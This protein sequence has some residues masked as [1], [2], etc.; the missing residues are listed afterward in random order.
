MTPT[1]S[2]PGRSVWWTFPA[3]MVLVLV[4]RA[5]EPPG[6]ALVFAQGEPPTMSPAAPGGLGPRL[7]LSH[8]F[9]GSTPSLAWSPD[10]QRL[11][12]NAA[13]EYFGYDEQISEH[14]RSLGL[15]VYERDG[16]AARQLV[17]QQRYHPAW[18]GDA[19]IASGCSP[20]ESCTPGLYL[21]DLAGV[22]VQ[23]LAADVYHTVA[24]SDSQVLFYNG[25]SGYTRWNRFDVRTAAHE[26]GLSA[27]CSWE[28]PP[29]LY[30]DQCVQQV[31]EVS[32][33]VDVSSGLWVRYGEGAPLH[34]D[35]TPPFEFSS[36]AWD[37]RED[38]SGPVAPCL[39][40]DGRQ[41]AYVAQGP[42]S[43]LL[44]VHELP[45]AAE[46]AAAPAAPWAAVVP[47][48]EGPREPPSYVFDDRTLPEHVVTTAPTEDA[49]QRRTTP[50]VGSDP[51]RPYLGFDFYGDTPSL[52]WSPDGRHLVFNA[53]YQYSEYLGGE[54][55]YEAA[56]PRLGLWV[57]EPAASS[58]RRLT[59]EERYHPAWV[60]DASLASSC[61][62]SQACTEGLMLTDLAG[63]S[64]VPLPFA[65]SVAAASADG[66]VLYYDDSSASWGRYDVGSGQREP[67]V[68]P[69]C[70]WEPPPALFRDH[71]VQQV[72][73][74]R[75]WVQ[76][77]IGLYAQ[78]G[79]G[80]PIRLDPTPPWLDE[81]G[82]AWGCSRESFTGPVEPC[83]SPDGRYVAYVARGTR[84]ELSLHVHELPR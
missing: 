3:A 43:L 27:S 5:A 32:V 16:E 55:Q 13:Y 24:A 10:G 4:W 48:R 67:N 37:C 73:D 31:G 50:A 68:S 77:G 49:L 25:F 6:G 54:P 44:R 11:A 66:Q 60:D 18:V 42:R 26:T 36:S 51:S 64:R 65:V 28:P 56:R 62:F 22:E 46:V 75:V 30:L 1:R 47:S 63:S 34:V 70:A 52:S 79:A 29:G 23:A 82:Y 76:A 71:C 38:H 39:S 2:T 58:A 7:V 81:E 80:P 61:S 15:W 59:N 78:V 33:A 74:A 69:S 21:T 17:S 14:A 8:S 19:Q 41:V 12:F 53:A 9:Y 35:A 40:P 20:Y 72:G 45:T 84:S 57:V 83:L